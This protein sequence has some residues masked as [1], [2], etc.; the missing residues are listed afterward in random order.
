MKKRNFLSVA[1]LGL[2]LAALSG[3]GGKSG[4]AFYVA[5]FDGGYGANWLETFVKEYLAQQKGVSPDQIVSGKDYRLVADADI[6]YT[7]GNY[8]KSKR[9]CPDLLITNNLEAKLVSDG[10][11]AGLSSLYEEEI[12]KMD[13]SKVKIKDYVDSSCANRFY[14]EKQLG[15]EASKD[16]WGIPWAA[17]PCSVA[18]NETLLQKITHYDANGTVEGLA[19]GA[20][21][22]LPPET[23]NDVFTYFKDID[24]YNAT[25]PKKVDKFGWAGKD[26]TQW[27]EFM[28]MTWF[29]ELHGTANDKLSAGKYSSQGTF[30]D[31]WK[32]DAKASTA[33]QYKWS[34]IQ[35]AL[36]AVKS[37]VTEDDGSQYGKYINSVM[38]ADAASIKDVQTKFADGDI[39]LCLTGDWFEHEY[40]NSLDASGQV[41]KT[42]FVPS[43]DGAITRKEDGKVAKLTYLTTDNVMFVPANAPHKDTA[44]GLLKY[45]TEERQ[46]IRFTQ[47]T[48]GIR[49]FDYDA[50][51]FESSIDPNFKYSNWQK[52]VFDIYYNADDRISK[53]PRKSF[54]EEGTLSPVYVYEGDAGRTLTY[55]IEYPTV[56]D[57]LRKNSGVDIMVN[58]FDG[59]VENAAY[60]IAKKG[61][62]EFES[63]YAE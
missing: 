56:I 63:R 3:C 24:N 62:A 37:L 38:N 55:G 4:D 30:D 5:Y 44:F 46:C 19:D 52:S 31:F 61:F 12:T 1:L 8:V 47:E 60:S 49:P 11:I 23:L 33:E 2:S 26:G 7:A 21:W 59:N 16:Y 25:A 27:F 39:A 20:K 58:G 57:K 54:A 35:D 9:D 10:Y 43:L 14:Y 45:M 51:N 41:I 13:G 42:M 28:T 53:F 17:I 50:R 32:L 22:T 34:G 48:G 29:A 15:R 6:T 18:Y 40:K 36:N